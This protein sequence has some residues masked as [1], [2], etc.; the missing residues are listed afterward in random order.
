MKCN[1]CGRELDE[2]EEY[3]LFCGNKLK[4]N[5]KNNEREIREK[6][7]IIRNQKENENK[8]IETLED[9]EDEK[10][11][12]I[13]EEKTDTTKEE[14]EN[15]NSETKVEYKNEKIN[16]FKAGGI[17]FLVLLPFLIFC[18]FMC[19]KSFYDG[20]N[21]PSIEFFG[22]IPELIASALY[23]YGAIIIIIIPIVV[24]IVCAFVNVLTG[25]GKKK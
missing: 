6:E 16:S 25:S 17:T 18:I 2:E 23:M 24:I 20:Y 1:R 13:M 8:K 14:K 22:P 15:D 4:N 5:Y 12:E 10:I 9:N 3:C 11:V 21:N 19:I 7:K